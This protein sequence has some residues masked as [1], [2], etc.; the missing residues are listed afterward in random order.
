M[1]IFFSVEFLFIFIFVAGWRYKIHKIIKVYGELIQL[2]VKCINI[3]R[4]KIQNPKNLTV[5]PNNFNQ[6]QNPGTRS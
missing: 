4:L 2:S 3:R 6:G 1:I 5:N